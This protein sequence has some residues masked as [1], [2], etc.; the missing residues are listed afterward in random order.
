MT[1]EARGKDSLSDFQAALQIHIFVILL[2]RQ[3]NDHVVEA[4]AVETVVWPGGSMRMR[5]RTDSEVWPLP[6]Q[7]KACATTS[8]I[9]EDGSLRSRPPSTFWSLPRPYPRTSIRFILFLR[10]IYYK[11]PF[12]SPR[13]TAIAVVALFRGK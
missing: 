10:P 4:T 7:A 12:F 13:P 8:T 3:L 1:W 2:R 6:A 11:S 9:P 5:Q